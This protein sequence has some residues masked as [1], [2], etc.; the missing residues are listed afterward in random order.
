MTRQH[1]WKTVDTELGGTK[2]FVVYGDK[3]LAVGGDCLRN[4]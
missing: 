1:T 2:S 4:R 3:L